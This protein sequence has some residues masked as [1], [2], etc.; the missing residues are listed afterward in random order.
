M[1]K[2][3]L[4]DWAS[5]NSH[6]FSELH[7]LC[8]AVIDGERFINLPV[9]Y[10]VYKEQYYYID[11]N[12]TKTLKKAATIDELLCGNSTVELLRSRGN[13]VAVVENYETAQSLILECVKNLKKHN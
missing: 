9:Q 5:Q 10:G 13:A 2:Q 8:E 1:T 3:N 12:R 7:L 11:A 6:K 4:F